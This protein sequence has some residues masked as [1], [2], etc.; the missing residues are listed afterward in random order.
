M[1]KLVKNNYDYY[2]NISE[3]IFRDLAGLAHIQANSGY[4]ENFQ[5]I[6]LN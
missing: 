2:I 3:Q 1:F 6:R 5:N 4:F